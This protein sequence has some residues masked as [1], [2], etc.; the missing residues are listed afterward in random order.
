MFSKKS[1]TNQFKYLI[2][3]SDKFLRNNEIKKIMFKAIYKISFYITINTPSLTFLKISSNISSAH[4]WKLTV[5]LVVLNLMISKMV[6]I[7][8]A[9][10]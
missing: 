5:T 8:L 7:R 2:N 4:P 1:Q 3:S 6:E 10:H 9:I